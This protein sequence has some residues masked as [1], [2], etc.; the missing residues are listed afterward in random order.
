MTLDVK[1]ETAAALKALASA[2]GL[3]I[4][5]YLE[6][7]LSRELPSKS[8][9]A[10][11]S[12]GSG[13]VWENGLFVYRTGRPLPS[14]LIDDAVHQIREARARQILDKHS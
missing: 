3:S 13:M 11:D 8:D 10:V 9:D 12:S 2:K 14:H 4:E 6:E 5:D 1:P 7:I